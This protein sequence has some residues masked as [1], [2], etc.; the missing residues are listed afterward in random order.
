[1]RSYSLGSLTV[2]DDGDHIVIKPEANSTPKIEYIRI[3]AAIPVFQTK[4]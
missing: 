3:A 1:M 2:A 4:D